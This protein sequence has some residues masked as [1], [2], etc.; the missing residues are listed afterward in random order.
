MKPIA[1]NRKLLRR[2]LQH[3]QLGQQ[4]HDCNAASLCGFATF[5]ADWLWRDERHSVM[6]RSR[7]RETGQTGTALAMAR[8]A[9]VRVGCSEVDRS[10]GRLGAHAGKPPPDTTP[11]RGGDVASYFG[12]P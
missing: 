1:P 10:L 12:V 5:L 6:Q 2:L 8:K 3:G 7:F 9:A 11:S 4:V